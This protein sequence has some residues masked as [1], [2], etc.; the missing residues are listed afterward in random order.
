MTAPAGQEAAATAEMGLALQRR[1]AAGETELFVPLA[2]LARREGRS[3][4]ALALL[5][6]GLQQW[7]RRVS[8]WVA[9]ARLKS[10]LGH[11]DEALGHYRDLL[12]GLDPRNL[13]ALRALAGAAL[14]RGDAA[15]A[16]G[17]LDRWRAE[18]PEDPELEDLCEEM[19]ALSSP[20]LAAEAPARS[21]ADG[22][23]AIELGGEAAGF[24]AAPSP[25]DGLAWAA[26]QPSRRKGS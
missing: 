19:A 3:Q 17:Y 12:D 9:L 4:E 5:E 15:G 20:W 8:G 16:R 25:A 18:D 23:L 11:V 14:A 10:Q 24:L 21:A 6:A 22:L 7:P 2:E 26:A 13:P 1:H